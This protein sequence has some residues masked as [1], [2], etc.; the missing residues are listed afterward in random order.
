MHWAVQEK[1][2]KA[3]LF[4]LENGASQIAV[5]EKGETPVELACRLGHWDCARDLIEY[6]SRNYYY[7]YKYGYT[8]ENL[9]YEKALLYAIE[10]GDYFTTEL[11]LKNNAPYQKCSSECG[12]I[13]LYKAVIS[14]RPE[15][16][17]LLIAY[18]ADANAKINNGNKTQTLR[19][20]ALE[21]GH[22]KCVEALDEN[23]IC[24]NNPDFLKNIAKRD[25]LFNKLKHDNIFIQELPQTVYSLYQ[26]Q[27]TIAKIIL[28]SLEEQ[29]GKKN[30]G[31]ENI[32]SLI[33]TVN[34]LL[35]SPAS[36]ISEAEFDIIFKMKTQGSIEA[37]YIADMLD[38][39]IK[40]DAFVN[41][42]KDWLFALQKTIQY[43]SW[44]MRDNAASTQKWDFTQMKFVYNRVAWKEGRPECVSLLLDK[45]KRLDAKPSHSDILELFLSVERQLSSGIDPSNGEHGYT[46]DFYKAK[47][48]EIKSI[49]FAGVMEK[50]ELK[51]NQDSRDQTF[52]AFCQRQPEFLYSNTTSHVLTLLLS[53]KNP[54]NEAAPNVTLSAEL[55]SSSSQQNNNN[56][57][58]NGSPMLFT[59][60]LSVS[61]E[62]EESEEKSLHSM[63]R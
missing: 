63:K 24:V 51:R 9:H 19:E 48:E 11:L 62:D 30:E 59:H 50:L 20:V 49:T 10:R 47:N 28:G 53:E 31:R 56:A 12:N 6:N 36:P 13:A 61:E 27:T 54:E 1:N 17:K 3:I 42:I 58:A 41:E 32:S 45:L 35:H 8:V 5:N 25:N 29:R 39:K 55:F 23:Q 14:N 16:V 15:I 21:H 34:T 44:Q 7:Y 18:K 46:I 52:V 40:V 60:S 38:C 33:L 43:T 22:V 2:N 37:S 4:L 57:V 26:H